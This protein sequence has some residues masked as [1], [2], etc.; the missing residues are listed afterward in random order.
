MISLILQEQNKE[1]D[2][3]ELLVTWG[4]TAETMVLM[5]FNKNVEFF[6]FEARWA[7]LAPLVSFTIEFK[8]TQLKTAHELLS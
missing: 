6:L 5:V 7:K 1:G 2:C 8:E 4:A 3:S